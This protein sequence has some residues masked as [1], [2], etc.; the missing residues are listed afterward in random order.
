MME[1]DIQWPAQL[2]PAFRTAA[3]SGIRLTGGSR[4]AVPW[5]FFAG[6]GGGF[7]GGGGPGRSQE[8]VGEAQG[9]VDGHRPRAQRTDGGPGPTAR[10]AVRRR[11]RQVTDRDA[12]G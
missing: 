10:G 3:T 7:V 4:D 6:A 1:R 5:S 11:R 9:D 12:G 2:P 8:G